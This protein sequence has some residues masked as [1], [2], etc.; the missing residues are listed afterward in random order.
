MPSERRILLQLVVDLR[1]DVVD[2][3]VP[4]VVV[5]VDPYLCF[6][7][8]NV[9]AEN[10]K[11]KCSHS[12]LTGCVHLC[13]PEYDYLDPQKTCLYPLL[14]FLLPMFGL[15]TSVYYIVYKCTFVDLNNSNLTP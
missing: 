2:L 14:M 11:R 10:W 8:K 15:N 3:E 13:D 4:V 12:F 9:F 6:C 5:V 1:V 7:L